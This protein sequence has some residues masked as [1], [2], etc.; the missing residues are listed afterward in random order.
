MSNEFNKVFVVSLEK[1]HEASGKSRYR[2]WKDT[3]V[4]PGTITRHTK[5]E[6]RTRHIGQPTLKLCDYYG[7]E[8]FDVVR[9]E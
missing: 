9:V 8:V 2:V 6:Y 1:Q 7:V 5:G 4:A 3:G